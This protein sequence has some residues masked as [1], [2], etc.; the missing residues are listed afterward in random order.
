MW[1]SITAELKPR[2]QK[3]DKRY[4]CNV[5][6]VY[7]EGLSDSRKASLDVDNFKAVL[8]GKEVTVT[9]RH[10]TGFPNDWL[11][12]TDKEPLCSLVLSSTHGSSK[13]KALGQINAK[14]SELQYPTLRVEDIKYV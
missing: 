10:R 11:A 2:N 6:R 5:F 12:E 7:R 13:T 3:Y 4:D 9:R 14:L 8:D 1:A